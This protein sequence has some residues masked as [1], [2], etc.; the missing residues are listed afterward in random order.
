[1]ILQNLRTWMT[2]GGPT[3]SYTNTICI[4]V[5]EKKTSFF[6][7][8][9]VCVL[10]S[11]SWGWIPIV[12]PRRIYLLRQRRSPSNIR[13]HRMIDILQPEFFLCFE[14]MFS[15]ALFVTSNSSHAPPRY[16]HLLHPSNVLCLTINCTN[17]IYTHTWAK[18]GYAYS[19]YG[20][21]RMRLKMV[22]WQQGCLVFHI[23]RL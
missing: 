14:N 15:K 6:A 8:A 18:H 7:Y 4:H 3:I 20:H 19:T 11:V 23:Y 16:R 12:L 22:A 10:C 17:T 21:R 9:Y 1:M 13:C 5:H 2:T